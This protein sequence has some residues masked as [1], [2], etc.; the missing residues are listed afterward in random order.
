MEQAQVVATVVHDP[1]TAFY[2]N[3]IRFFSTQDAYWVL[4][5]INGC[6]AITLCILI[7]RRIKK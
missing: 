3:I 5:G 6:I 1:L 2:G 7:A 4:L